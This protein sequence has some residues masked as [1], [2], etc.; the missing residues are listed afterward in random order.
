M[1]NEYGERLDKCGYAESIIPGHSSGSCWFCGANGYNDPMNRHEVF[2]GPYRAKSKRLGLW[3]HLCHWSCHQ[4]PYG[5]HNNI[6]RDL[7]LKRTA[8]E[9]AMNYYGWTTNEFIRQFGKNYL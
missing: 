9:Y 8:Q 5:V 3:V 4:G 1:T 7:V 6:D 2:G